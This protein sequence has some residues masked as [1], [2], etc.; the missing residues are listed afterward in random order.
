MVEITETSDQ[1]QPTDVF[2]G[3]KDDTPA[4]VILQATTNIQEQ[5]R[6]KSGW[7]KHFDRKQQQKNVRI[8]YLRSL[9]ITNM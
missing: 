3:Y 1:F 8:L 4:A 7:A 6:S 5:K 9:A 2:V